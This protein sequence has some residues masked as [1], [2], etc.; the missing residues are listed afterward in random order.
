MKCATGKRGYESRAEARDAKRIVSKNRDA[1]GLRAYLCGKCGCWHLGTRAKHDQGLPENGPAVPCA[2]R[3]RVEEHLMCPAA[4]TFKVSTSAGEG[5]LCETHWLELTA[6]VRA[7]TK[8]A[9]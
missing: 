3:I 9:A 1:S 2:K 7:I 5:W 6:H 8:K 4:G